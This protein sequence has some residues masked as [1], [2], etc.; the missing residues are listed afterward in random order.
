[1]IW[2][3]C[4]YYAVI[5]WFIDKIC[6][7]MSKQYSSVL[8]IWYKFHLCDFLEFIWEIFE[9]SNEWFEYGSR[10]KE[11]FSLLLAE[12]ILIFGIILKLSYIDLKGHF[13]DRKKS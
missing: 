6:V 2:N 1:M 7:E 5:K 3:T 10:F 12:I 4:S 13:A 9:G 11:S 8:L